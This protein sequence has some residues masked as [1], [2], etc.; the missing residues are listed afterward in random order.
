MREKKNIIEL[1]RYSADRYRSLPK[2]DFIVVTDNVRSLHNIGAIFRTSD[3]FG[4]SEIVLCGI[5]GTPPHPE[6]HKSSLGAE[7]SVRW[8]HADDTYEECLRLVS[9]GWRIMVL[10][11]A[12]GSV[13]P[14]DIDLSPDSKIALVVGNEVEGVDQRIVSLADTVIEIPQIGAKHSLNVSVSA[15][16]AIYAIALKM[17]ILKV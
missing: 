14:E 1:T 3:A 17:K 6:L 12:Y 13:T 11:Q 16:I 2:K 10:E 8:R 4:V 9:E 7:D 15:G 5:S